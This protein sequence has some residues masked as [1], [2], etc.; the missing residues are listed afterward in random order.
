MF[1]NIKN[2][3]QSH[4][5]A[6]FGNIYLKTCTFYML[7]FINIKYPKAKKIQLIKHSVN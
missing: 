3:I 6:Q 4:S 1:K 5:R 7:K 2:A